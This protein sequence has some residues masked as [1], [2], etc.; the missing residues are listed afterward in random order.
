[1][2]RLSDFELLR[3]HLLN[4]RYLEASGPQGRLNSYLNL[5]ELLSC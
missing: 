5:P 4:E 2:P 1:M 3:I